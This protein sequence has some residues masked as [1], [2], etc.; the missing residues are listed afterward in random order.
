MFAKQYEN[1]GMLSNILSKWYDWFHAGHNGS[2][3]GIV[4]FVHQENTVFLFHYA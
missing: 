3:N 2:G 1:P 4:F